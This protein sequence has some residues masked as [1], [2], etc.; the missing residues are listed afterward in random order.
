[1]RI[2]TIYEVGIDDLRMI[3]GGEEGE[4][5]TYYEGPYIVNRTEKIVKIGNYIGFGGCR[6]SYLL[7]I[8]PDNNSDIRDRSETPHSYGGP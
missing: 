5:P 2:S 3:G 7:Y 1:M 8:V 6:R 4:T